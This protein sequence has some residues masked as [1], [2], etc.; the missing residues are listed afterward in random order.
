MFPFPVD[1]LTF[2]YIWAALIGHTT[3]EDMKLGKRLAGE[4][5]ELEGGRGGCDNVYMV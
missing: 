2:L 1:D 4:L 3:K 5:G